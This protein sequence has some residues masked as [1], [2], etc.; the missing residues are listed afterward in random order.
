MLG[1]VVSGMSFAG[2]RRAS[3]LLAL[4][5]L[6]WW[7]HPRSAAG[8]SLPVEGGFMNWALTHLFLNI[9]LS[10]ISISECSDVHCT[11]DVPLAVS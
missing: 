4:H 1:R 11:A 9:C 8:H 7:Q 10:K 5:G 2:K 3:L 6:H